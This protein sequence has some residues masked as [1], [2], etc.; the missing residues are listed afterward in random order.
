[1]DAAGDILDVS[2]VKNLMADFQV[3]GFDKVKLVM[4][5]FW[6]FLITY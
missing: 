5:Y 6:F 4:G 2:T 1:M 3:F